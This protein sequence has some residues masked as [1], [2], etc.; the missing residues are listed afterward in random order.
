LSERIGRVAV[1]WNQGATL[2]EIADEIEVSPATAGNDRKSFD[3]QVT[4]MASNERLN[5]DESRELCQ[6]ILEKLEVELF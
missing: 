5:A 3:D 4:E 6:A 2:R 1:L